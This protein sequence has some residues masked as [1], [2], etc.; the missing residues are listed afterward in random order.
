[1]ADDGSVHQHRLIGE[2]RPDAL[3][4]ELLHEVFAET[5]ARSPTNIALICGETK[6]TYAE[7]D[8]AAGKVAAWLH[9]RDLGRGSFVGLWMSRS[10]ELHVVLL[11][12]LKSGAAYIPLDADAPADRVATSLGDCSAPVVI[13]DAYTA[14]EFAKSGIQLEMTQMVFAHELLVQGSDLTVPAPR[15][16]GADPKDPAYAIY[17]SGR[18]V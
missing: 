1:M 17:T 7:L 18:R 3:R 9:S 6:L 14:A 11:G 12:I 5:V 13:V 4:D 2:L 8:R 15:V 10:S 16:G